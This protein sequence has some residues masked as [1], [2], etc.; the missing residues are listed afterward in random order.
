MG[1][2]D[3]SL[4]VA[5]GGPTAVGAVL[6][7]NQAYHELLS[8][9]HTLQWGIAFSCPRLAGL[10]AGNEFRE[11]WIEDG[12]QV[13]AA[14]AAV[15]AHFGERGVKCHR[16]ALAEAQ[17][18][19]IVEPGLAEAGF[20]RED[21]QVLALGAWSEPLVVEHVRVL[22]ARPMR[23]A[24]QAVLEV[25]AGE[26]APSAG[27]Q[28]VEAGVDRLDDHRMDMYVAMIEGKA[29]GACALFQVGDIGRIVDLYVVPA[30][31]RRRAATGLLHHVM[32]LARRLMLRIVCVETPES[33]A[34]GIELLNGLGFVGAGRTV[35]FH[36]PQNAG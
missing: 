29:A 26:Y 8:G 23:A 36:A 12:G 32:A 10:S 19:G 20:V 15:D 30:F 31:R 25:A 22:P 7:T 5:S 27:D 3:L 34:A 33:N 2:V 17:D 24:Y 9:K 13:G 14:L 21:L 6:R 1:M 4:Q 35:Q 18:P 16:W 11:V 28:F